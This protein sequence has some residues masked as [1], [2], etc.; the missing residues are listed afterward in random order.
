MPHSKNILIT[1]G[2]G[3]VGSRLTTLL[4]KQ[5]YD[6]SHLGRS[7][8][9]KGV[10]TFLWDPMRNEI[11][12]E[13]LKNISVVVHLAGAGIADKRWNA[14][15]KKEILESRTQSAR[16]IRNA[17]LKEGHQMDAFISASGINYYGLEDA[18]NAFVE[19]DEPG[20]D[21]MARV[22]Y[23]WEREADA[24]AALGVRVVKI[25]TGV[26]LS[27]DSIALRRIAFPVKLFVGAPLG[28]GRQYFNWIHLDDLCCMY[29]RAIEDHSLQGPYNGVS[30]DPVTN[31]ALTREIAD[32]LKRPL[33]L[34]GVP[35]FVVRAVAGE[36]ADIVLKGG[37]VSAD[38]IQ[39]AG[40]HFQFPT[41]R[42]ALEN[43]YAE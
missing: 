11:E 37:R 5:G 14:H 15:R 25:R 41:L 7:R 20:N 29:L 8:K 43:I 3:M 12:K 10:K 9:R 34:P 33:W 21:F 22:S 35:A 30:P 2:S 42:S 16:L 31:S 4:V 1:G 36:V 39:E 6:V 40:F 19:S 32:I 24:F 17:L 18:G 13:A 38:K 28:T 23:A 26:V 27:R